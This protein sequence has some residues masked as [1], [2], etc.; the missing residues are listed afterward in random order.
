MKKLIISQLFLYR[1]RFIIGYILL[2]LSFIFTLF[3]LPTIA[4]A[5]LSD[6]ELKSAAHSQN[7][8]PGRLF[9][10]NSNQLVNFPYH[11]LQ[12]LSISLFETTPYSIKLPSIFF[13]LGLGLLLVLLLN[14]WFKNNVAL[15]ASVFTILSPIFLFLAGSGTP[16]IM[17]VFWPTLL[18]WLG[19]KIQIQKQPK[20]PHLILFLCLLFFSSFTPYLIYITLAIFVFAILK[21]HLRFTIKKLSLSQFI[22]LSLLTIPAIAFFSL[23]IILN[24]SFRS[25]I[26]PISDINLSLFFQN[27]NLAFTPFFSWSGRVDN[28]FLSPFV[29]LAT[30]A[31]AMAGLVS[32]TKGLFASRNSIAVLFIFFTIFISG[33][34]PDSAVLIILP[35]SILIA[36][37]IR[38]ILEKWYGLFPENPY[39]R[40]FAIFP[41]S[42]F[43]LII[44]TSSLS[45]FIFGYRYNPLVSQ[46]FSNDLELILG[47]SQ[48]PSQLIIPDSHPHLQFYQSL[49]LKNL[50]VSSKLDQIQSNQIL[51]LSQPLTHPE[52]KLERIITSPKSSNSARIYLYKKQ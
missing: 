34:E 46:Y 44:T 13:A 38:Y 16:L 23:L 18:L 8:S 41:I 39:A 5:G 17:L 47:H 27:L 25:E 21:P 24:S 32:T 1:H 28:L 20:F 33:F 2:S 9:D 4:P 30:F 36:H 40:I 45:Y 31:L 26:S 19:S 51:S 11:L 52:I 7:L 35:L 10:L 14:R 15:I 22:S 48:Q 6:A 37:G 43:I 42:A 50:S 29:N 12:K 49:T 3:F